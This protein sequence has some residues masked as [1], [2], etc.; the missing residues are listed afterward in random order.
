MDPYWCANTC[1]CAGI[2]IAFA[3]VRVNMKAL[4]C[5]QYTAGAHVQIVRFTKA[6]PTHVTIRIG[7]II[8]NIIVRRPL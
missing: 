1:E 4:M 5:S 2:S 3:H 6:L 7:I 8:P